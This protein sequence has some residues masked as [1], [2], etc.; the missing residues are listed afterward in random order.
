M[1]DTHDHPIAIRDLVLA[2]GGHRVLDGLSLSVA[3]GSI[4][5]LLGGN[6]AG[7]STTLT[8]PRLHG[9]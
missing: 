1:C 2:Y 3:A 6:G 8:I 5:A 9:G 7:K 4:T